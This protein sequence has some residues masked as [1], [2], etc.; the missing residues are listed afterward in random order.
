MTLEA[1][2]GARGE[3]QPKRIERYRRTVAQEEFRIISYSR[4]LREYK[5]IAGGNR[6]SLAPNCSSPIERENI[7]IR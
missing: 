6:I 2:S 7:V 3:S 5:A 4:A 1:M